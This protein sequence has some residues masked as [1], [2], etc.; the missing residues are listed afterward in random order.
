[1][2][3]EIKLANATIKVPKIKNPMKCIALNLCWELMNRDDS[4]AYCNIDSDPQG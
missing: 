1:M 4:T 2:S 3:N